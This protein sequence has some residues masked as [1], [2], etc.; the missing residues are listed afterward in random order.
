MYEGDRVVLEVKGVF[1]VSN[2]LH[3][4][5]GPNSCSTLMSYRDRPCARDIDLTYV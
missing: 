5:Q 4:R 2:D 3:A 1:G